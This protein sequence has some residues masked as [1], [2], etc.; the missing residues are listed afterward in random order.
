MCIRDSVNNRIQPQLLDGIQQTTGS[1]NVSAQ[2]LYGRGETDKGIALRRQMQD[3]IRL[4]FVEHM[5]KAGHIVEV[6]VFYEQDVYK[7]QALR[8]AA[9]SSLPKP[10][11]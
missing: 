5:Q 2:R 1:Q 8:T 9:R 10:L 7:R 6:A 3:V 11:P 4:H